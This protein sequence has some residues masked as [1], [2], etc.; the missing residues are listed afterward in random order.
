M[1][2]WLRSQTLLGGCNRFSLEMPSPDELVSFCV[3]G[4]KVSAKYCDIYE[5][6]VGYD[7]NRTT[8]IRCGFIQTNCWKL[9]DFSWQAR[10]TILTSM[11]QYARKNGLN[12]SINWRLPSTDCNEEWSLSWASTARPFLL[13][14][15]LRC[16][17]LTDCSRRV[18]GTIAE[19]NVAVLIDTSGTR[20]WSFS[21]IHVINFHV[22]F[23]W[24]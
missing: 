11:S 21:S 22:N 8:G 12:T 14:L 6:A 5:A 24:V 15:L 9:S 16:S 17:W 18:F 20:H 23:D 19:R 3:S 7:A 1:T 2:A 4:S 10:I 13:T